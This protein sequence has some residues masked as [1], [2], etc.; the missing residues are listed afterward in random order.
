MATKKT[1][2]PAVVVDMGGDEIP[3]YT[4]PTTAQEML[5]AVAEHLG[6]IGQDAALAVCVAL[7]YSDLV[8][9]DE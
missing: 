1:E 2:P 5:G 8:G 9:G 6:G 3:T 4:L 7:A